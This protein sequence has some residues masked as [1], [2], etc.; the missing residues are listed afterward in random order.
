MTDLFKDGRCRADEDITLF[1]PSDVPRLLD[2][3][4]DEFEHW[5]TVY[6]RACR[7]KKEKRTST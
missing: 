7:N 3:Y 2:T 4:G 6:E 1:C 5:Y